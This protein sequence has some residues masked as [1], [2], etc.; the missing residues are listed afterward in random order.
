MVWHS[1][2]AFATN[3]DFVSLLVVGVVLG[4]ARRKDLAADGRGI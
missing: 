3:S 4:R 1:A 2:S